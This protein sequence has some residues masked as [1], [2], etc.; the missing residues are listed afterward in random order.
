M[1]P[2]S[3]FVL[4]VE[5]HPD[6]LVAIQM[7][8]EFA[9]MEVATACD[10]RAALEVLGHR[11]RPALMLLDDMLPEMERARL[12][13]FIR[14]EPLLHSVP[15]VLL[16]VEDFVRSCDVQ[17]VLHKPFD[18]ERLYG[19]VEAHREVPRE[20]HPK[21]LAGARRRSASGM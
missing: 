8:L 18:L 7:A 4:V 21:V 5:G 16:S 17:A 2:P 20:V 14:E 11:G 15:I 19:V 12:V 3:S 9:G 6:V 1:P 13:R 10:A